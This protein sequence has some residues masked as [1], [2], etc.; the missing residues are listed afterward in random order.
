MAYTH[1][2]KQIDQAHEN[3]N[4]IFSDIQQIQVADIAGRDAKQSAIISAISL[5]KILDNMGLK[6][7]AARFGR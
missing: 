2:Q 6:H 4:D 5:R 1:K 3:L 7:S